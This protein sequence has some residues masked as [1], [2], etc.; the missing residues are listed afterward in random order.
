MIQGISLIWMYYKKL[1]IFTKI[2]FYFGYSI[3]T[4]IYL[5]GR[6]EKLLDQMNVDIANFYKG[7]NPII[8]KEKQKAKEL[9]EEINKN[10][11]NTLSLTKEE[12]KVFVKKRSSVN[13]GNRSK[14]SRMSMTQKRPII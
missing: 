12:S 11:R 14:S 1:L 9:E 3:L 4:L 7:C 13:V 5:L 2:L 10:K 6:F 8:H